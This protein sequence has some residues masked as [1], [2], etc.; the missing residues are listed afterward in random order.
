MLTRGL[1]EGGSVIM[2]MTIIVTVTIITIMAPSL[3]YG[4]PTMGN[5]VR[6]VLS[7]QPTEDKVRLREVE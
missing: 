2:I 1:G 5:F 3:I 7:Y 6:K 4:I